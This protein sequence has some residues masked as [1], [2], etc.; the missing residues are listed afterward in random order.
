MALEK[1]LRIVKRLPQNRFITIMAVP[2]ANL[3]V[4]EFLAKKTIILT[5]KA[6]WRKRFLEECFFSWSLCARQILPLDIS[7]CF[8]RVRRKGCAVTRA[9][10]SHQYGLGSNPAGNAIIW[11]EFI[12]GSRPCYKR[13]FF[14]Y[15]SFFISSRTNSF[16]VQ[17]DQEW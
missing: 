13:F 14:G 8:E 12:V 5:W 3:L 10:A 1:S 2:L 9:P 16:K 17:F 6:R 4:L 7:C 11:C 15:F